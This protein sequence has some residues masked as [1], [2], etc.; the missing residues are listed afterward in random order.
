MEDHLGAGDVGRHVDED[1]AGASG[2]GD[3]ERLAHGGGQVIG[4]LQQEAVLD[5]GHRDAHDVGFLERVGA[6]DGALH[7]AGDHDHGHAVHIGGGDGGD[8]VRGARPA[9]HEADAGSPGHARV[10]V[11]HM[12]RAL[13][14]AREDV[15][16]GRIVERVVDFDDGAAGI[17]ED[18]VDALGL[19]GSDDGARAGH[20]LPLVRGRGPGS[21]RRAGDGGAFE[22]ELFGQIHHARYA[23]L[24]ALVTS[25]A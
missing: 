22:L 1:G 16:D 21:E 2:R 3:V 11:G 18:H 4:G 19:E 17:P 7:L 24:S 6:D 20:L 14:V 8:D 25:F 23:P 10:A 12:G 13:L 9:R 15:T 5:D